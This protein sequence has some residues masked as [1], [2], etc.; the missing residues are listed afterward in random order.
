MSKEPSRGGAAGLEGVTGPGRVDTHAHIMVRQAKL[1]ANRHSEP[2][3]DI[4]AEDFLTL[5]DHHGMTHGVLTQ[6]SFYG[7]DNSLLLQALQRYPTRLRGTAIVDPD[8][9]PAQLDRLFAAGVRGL[10]LNWLRQD[11]LPDPSGPAYRRLFDLARARGL[12]IELY[13]EGRKMAPILRAITHTGVAVV[14][15]HFGSPEPD[16]GLDGEGFRAVLDAVAAGNT[17]VKL[18]AP[19]RL[20]GV[21]AQAYAQALLEARG[22]QQLMWGSDWPWVS[23]EDTQRYE[24]CL[25]DFSQWVPDP[26]ERRIIEWETPAR[27]FDF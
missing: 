9:E 21:P 4:S 5:L 2:K 18:S 22:P 15:D 24:H 7:T 3:H 14:L 13:V 20:G 26:A 6:P 12:H 10:R 8:I 19:Y 1:V 25:A 23:H 17:W 11:A 27:V 16:H